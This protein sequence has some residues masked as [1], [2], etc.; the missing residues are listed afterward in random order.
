MRTSPAS[1]GWK[2]SS[3]RPRVLKRRRAW[4]IE[5]GFYRFHRSRSSI[6]S[7]NHEKPL[8]FLPFSLLSLGVCENFAGV[9]LRSPHLPGP[10]LPEGEEGERHFF[11]WSCSP[12]SPRERGA[13]GVRASEGRSPINSQALGE[14]RAG[15]VRG[16]GE[17]A[18]CFSTKAG[19]ASEAPTASPSPTPP[20]SRCRPWDCRRS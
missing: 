5:A 11:S 19:A 12:L 13:R 10:P 9:P 2:G 14:R 15:E 6:L 18:L 7:R 1:S 8:S 16:G 4:G 17:Q 20:P 3:R